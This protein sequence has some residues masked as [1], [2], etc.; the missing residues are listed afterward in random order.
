[1]S[2]PIKTM[3]I[4]QDADLVIARQCARTIAEALGFD[5]QDQ[6]RIATAVSEIARN[7]FLY[8][9]GGEIGFMLDD[10][11]RPQ[12]FTIR[13]TDSGPGIADLDAVLTGRYRSPQGLGLGL[14]GAKRLMDSLDVAAMPGRGTA[15]TMGKAVPQRDG[16]GGWTAEELA[17]I[18]GRI[19]AS[20]PTDVTSALRAQN[21]ELMQA[22]DE[23]RRRQ[24]EA[25]ELNKELGDTNRGVVA[26]YAEL[27]EHAEHLR[28]ASELKSRFLAHMSHEFRTPLNSILALARML[29]DKLDGELNGEQVRQVGYIRRSADSLLELVNDLLDLSKVQ[30]GKV[31]VKPHAFTVA[32][33]FS[34]L[35]GALKP[36]QVNPAVELTFEDGEDIPSL[37]SDE[38]KVGQILRNFISNALKFTERGQ[39]HVSAA[40]DAGNDEVT[41]SVRDTGIGIA[42]ADHERI[43]EEFTQVET[44]LHGKVKGTGLGL[45]LSRNLATLLGGSIMLESVPG[46]GSVFRLALPVTFREM[47]CGHAAPGERQRVLLI[48]DDE[49]SRYVTRQL[50]AAD[51]QFTPV[52]AH[53]GIEG[54]RLAREEAPAVIVLDLLMPDMDG[55][56]VL[57][58]LQADAATRSIPVV[59]ATSLPIDADLK[60]KLPPGIPLVSKQTLSRKSV[61]AMLRGATAA[62]MH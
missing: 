3:P 8:A 60:E 1:M 13:I 24:E 44:R 21:V 62:R 12:I 55:F 28:R 48:D 30:A 29:L 25:M 53:N 31:D 23:I 40:Y 38:G 4:R 33:L 41:F 43:F 26:L 54:L 20:A 10:E 45:P 47:R 39:V 57:R 22:L 5:R 11:A 58:Y 15:V 36:L 18:A 7:A 34:G 2:W 32:E 51:P 50:I 52:E 16:S 14:A 56:A 9:G 59:I 49:A 46:Q 19:D 42:P 35:R 6:T 37:H 17:A 27:E 61:G